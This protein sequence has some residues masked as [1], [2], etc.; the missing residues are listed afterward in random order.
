M[1]HF[2]S[3]QFY[4][5]STPSGLGSRAGP[6]EIPDAP[7]PRDLASGRPRSLVLG[8]ATGVRLAGSHVLERVF[9]R[10]A[11]MT[12]RHHRLATV[13]VSGLADLS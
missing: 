10:P 11:P 4:D 9:R 8:L 6:H 3:R 2:F 12:Y 1:E 5:A 7:R 13:A